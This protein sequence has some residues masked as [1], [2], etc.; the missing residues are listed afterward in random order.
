MTRRRRRRKEEGGGR[1]RYTEEL[2]R[3]G[4]VRETHNDYVKSDETKR[5]K[6]MS[7]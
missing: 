6:T 7:A 4:R 3:G 1:R 2:P 5:H